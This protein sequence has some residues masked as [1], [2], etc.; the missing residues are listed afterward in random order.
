MRTTIDKAGRLVIPSQLRQRVG[1][2]DG[3]EVDVELD[4]GAIRVEPVVARDLV[5][6]SDLLVIPA[7][8]RSLDVATVRDLIDADRYGDDV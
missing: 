5:E 1:L 3:G 2:G 8:G 7:T 4:G 6:E